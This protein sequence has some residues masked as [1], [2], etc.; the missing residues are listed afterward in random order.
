MSIQQ[1]SLSDI[2][3][4]VVND[5]TPDDSM[6]I[7]RELAQADDRIKIL[8]HEKN[9]G[10]MW[11]RRTGYMAAI[12]DYV[13]F[14]DS[15]DYL[16]QDAL[17]VLYQKAVETGADIVS[18]N[19]TYVTTSN[20]EILKR[21]R[22]PYGNNPLGVYKALLCHDMR[23]SLWGKL[24]KRSLLQD[25]DYQT[26]EHATNGEDGCLFY[27]VVQHANEMMQINKSVYY[28]MQNE[29]SSTQKRYNENA[30]RSICLSNRMKVIT[31]SNFSSLR[32]EL[33]RYITNYLCELYA[34]G[35]GEGVNLWKY[36]H[37]SELENYLT[38]RY[39]IRYLNFGNFCKVFVS[40]FINPER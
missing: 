31:M 23:H 9:M 32:E 6:T 25:N 11:T 21:N 33:N 1:Q 17:D 19:Y 16:P 14:C 22:L 4:I 24:F 27:Q 36:I 37:Q 5:A 18:G 30:I 35:Y 28:Y 15:D 13:T 40:R 20:K 38:M 7:V 39:I 8:E 12:G 34:K 10:L 3:I 29:N 26:Y 2:E